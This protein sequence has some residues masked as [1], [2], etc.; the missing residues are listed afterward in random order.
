M[1]GDKVDANQFSVISISPIVKFDELAL[2]VSRE[3][4][5]VNHMHCT[6][7]ITCKT[8]TYQKV[9]MNDK[10]GE[11]KWMCLYELLFFPAECC[12]N[13]VANVAFRYGVP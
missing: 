3:M 5:V 13:M 6:H 2:L 9:Q 10:R 11:H 12:V 7:T 4:K 1:E 8:V